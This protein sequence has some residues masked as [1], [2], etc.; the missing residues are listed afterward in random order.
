[1]ATCPHNKRPV[2]Q[3]IKQWSLSLR[4]ANSYGL[5]KYQLASEGCVDVS[6]RRYACTWTEES[7]RLRACKRVTPCQN[8]SLHSDHCPQGRRNRLQG[9]LWVCTSYPCRSAL[10]L[11][12]LEDSG[13]SADTYFELMKILQNPVFHIPHIVHL[14]RK[15]ALG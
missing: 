7:S 2:Q 12:L 9:Y 10:A 13:P 15:R 11:S 4:F 1:M 6:E 14:L 5:C 3:A 8:K